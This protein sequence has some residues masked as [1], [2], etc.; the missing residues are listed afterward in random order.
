[1]GQYLFTCCNRTVNIPSTN[2]VSGSFAHLCL[3]DA[4]CFGVATLVGVSL[5]ASDVPTEAVDPV[6]GVV[7]GTD[8]GS[9]T[10]GDGQ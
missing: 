4:P 7:D 10:N 8:G 9:A 2:V 6:T 5:P 3:N 1:M